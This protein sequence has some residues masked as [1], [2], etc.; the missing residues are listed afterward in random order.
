VLRQQRAK[1]EIFKLSGDRFENEEIEH[2]LMYWAE[3]DE[4]VK[5][6]MKEFTEKSVKAFVHEA[7]KNVSLYE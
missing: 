2:A 4:Q 5:Q 7:D 6:E 3:R 1:D